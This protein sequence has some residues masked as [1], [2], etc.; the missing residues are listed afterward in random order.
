M[1]EW[2]KST[3]IVFGIVCVKIMRVRVVAYH[4]TCNSPII[5]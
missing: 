4:V 1:K 5:L 2:G 3:I